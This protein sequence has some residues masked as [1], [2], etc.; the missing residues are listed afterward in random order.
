MILEIANP[1]DKAIIDCTNL[2]AAQLAV[3]IIGNGKY[4]ITDNTGENGM[5]SFVLGGINEWPIE[6]H[7]MSL[8]QALDA[9]PLSEIIKALQSVKLC[10]ERTSI[11][12]FTT[13][14]HE[15]AKTLKDKGYL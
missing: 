3:L 15:I 11:N 14:A 10:G 8:E 2:L 6:K 1:R 12:D 5:P 7:G 9:T 4:G 13:R